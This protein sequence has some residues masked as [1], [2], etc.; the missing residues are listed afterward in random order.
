[1]FCA[2]FMRY[3]ALARTSESGVKS[4]VRALADQGSLGSASAFGGACHA[5]EGETCACDAACAH[6]NGEP[7]RHA[8]DVFVFAFREFVK[9]GMGGGAGQIEGEAMDEFAGSQVLLA[10]GDEEIFEGDVPRAC[11]ACQ[12]QL[13]AQRDE[14]GGQVADG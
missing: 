3:S 14:G 6:F 5:A 7:C 11:S 4:L 8:G 10:V 1:M 2:A 13:C 12:S 9:R